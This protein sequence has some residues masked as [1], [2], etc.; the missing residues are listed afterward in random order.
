MCPR[1]IGRIV[2]VREEVILVT[3]YPHP[4]RIRVQRPQVTLSLVAIVVLAAALVGLGAWVAVDRL[5]GGAT[6]TATNDATTLIDNELA[7]TSAGNV[8]AAL[9]LYTPDATVWRDGGVPFTG[10]VQIRNLIKVAN[11]WGPFAATRIAPVNVAGAWATTYY[12]R[13]YLNKPVL[14][15]FQ[16]RDGKIFREWDFGLAKTNPFTTHPPFTTTPQP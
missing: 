8:N 5:T 2:G 9:A 15:V 11:G 1:G 6:P 14:A 10:T 13:P 16:L 12:Q 4:H 7:Y 3:T